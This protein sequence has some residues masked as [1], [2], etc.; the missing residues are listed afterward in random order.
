M[1]TCIEFFYNMLF[2][3]FFHLK[4]VNRIKDLIVEMEDDFLMIEMYI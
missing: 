1:L 2:M 3:I 4:N